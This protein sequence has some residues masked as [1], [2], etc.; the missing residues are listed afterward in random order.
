MSDYFGELAHEV[1]LIEAAVGD[2]IGGYTKE[3]YERI[4][5]LQRLDFLR[6]SLEDMSTLSAGITMNR[7]GFVAKSVSA[8]LRLDTSKALFKS[9]LEASGLRWDTS[10]SSG[11]LDLF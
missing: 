3:G 1:Q 4:V 11:E 6:Q 5:R 8:E 2:E 7:N 9:S 10:G